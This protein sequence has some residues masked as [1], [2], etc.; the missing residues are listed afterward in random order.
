MTG[1]SSGPGHVAGPGGTFFAGGQVPLFMVRPA[2]HGAVV[3]LV[4]LA[5]CTGF[6]EEPPER[7]ERAV[8]AV[9]ESM[10]AL[11]AV[12]TYRY[13]TDLRVQATADGR[14]E[15]VH[16]IVTGAVDSSARRMNSTTDVDGRTVE[17]YL[18]NRTAYQ[19]CS[20]I[21]SFWGVEN[22]T[23]E[24]WDALTPAYRQLALLESGD[25]RYEGKATVDGRAATHVV[26]EPSADALARYR[27]D[28]SQPIFGGPEIHDVRLE[29]WIE[30]E[31]DLPIRTRLRFS[32][33]SGDGSGS[34]RMETKFT[35]FGDPVSID[36]P[37][38]ARED[39]LEL[40]CPG[41]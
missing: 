25:L 33:S 12:E 41:S 4:L 13:E 1:A 6:L 34:A 11:D 24:D 5:G 32:L 16:A 18:L 29:V 30:N 10:A 15:R 28:R 27:E 22:E 19:Q 23:A 38:E 8:A 35:D 2:L 21:R 14:T 40:G 17:A 9:E 39:Q 7:D 36:L 3:L 37:E 31:T 20:R 26:G